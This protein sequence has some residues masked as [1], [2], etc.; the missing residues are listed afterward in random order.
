VNLYQD[1]M[2]TTTPPGASRAKRWGNVLACAVLIVVIV[3][4]LVATWMPAI[5]SARMKRVGDAAAT[6]PTTNPA[7]QSADVPERAG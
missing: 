1:D 5:V 3:G 7:T 4:L 6:Q 2:T